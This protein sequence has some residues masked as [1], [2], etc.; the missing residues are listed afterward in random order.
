MGSCGLANERS[1]TIGLHVGGDIASTKG[2]W[3]IGFGDIINLLNAGGTKVNTVKGA[4]LAGG[5]GGNELSDF[6]DSQGAGNGLNAGK[7]LGYA[8]LAL[9]RST[10]NRVEHLTVCQVTETYSARQTPF[11]TVG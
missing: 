3:E 4:G 6:V 2:R 10:V 7:G 8:Q 1:T 11:L 9:L 5:D